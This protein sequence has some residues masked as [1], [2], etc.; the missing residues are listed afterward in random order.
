MDKLMEIMNEIRPDV[1][2]Q[3]EVKLIDEDILDSFDVIAI[4]SEVNEAFGIEININ[5]LIPENF[6][7]IHA[8]FRLIQRLQNS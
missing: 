4:V 6:N 7:S 2:F 1:D 5:D 3:K 8:L